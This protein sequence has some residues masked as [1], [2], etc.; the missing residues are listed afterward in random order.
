MLS[1]C[2]HEILLKLDIV[3]QRE[4]GA[5]AETERSQEDVDILQGIARDL[6]LLAAS[7][8]EHPVSLTVQGALAAI[9]T[10]EIVG[11]K[12]CGEVIGHIEIT[13]ALS[14]FIAR[15]RATRKDECL[16]VFSNRYATHYTPAG[17]NTEWSKLMNKALGLKKIG[18]RF[19]FHDLHAY[20]VTR[21][22]ADVVRCT[23]I[24]RWRHA[25]TIERKS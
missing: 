12:K 8:V 11:G 6:D 19:T 14:E 18:R 1:Q 22:K 16:Y 13:P 7:P 3:D 2:A 4:G 10:F 15:L 20:Y 25:S 23:R 17:F 5:S 21:H 9:E 24:R